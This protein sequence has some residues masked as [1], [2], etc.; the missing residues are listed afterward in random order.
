MKDF[1][2]LYQILDKEVGVFVKMSSRSAKDSVLRS[3]KMKSLL[4]F[5]LSKYVDKGTAKPESG[6]IEINSSKQMISFVRAQSKAMQTFSGK[7]AVYN[8]YT[9]QRTHGDITLALLRDNFKMGVV[10][11]LWNPKL[12]PECEFRGINHYHS[13][14]HVSICL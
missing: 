4:K 13:Y 8:F 3:D 5:E 9:S 10:L 7:E 11:R 6:E 2:K 1:Q 12:I 14:Q